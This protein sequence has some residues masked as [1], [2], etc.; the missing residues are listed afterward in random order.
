MRWFEASPC[1]A[2]PEGQPPSLAQLRARD[3]YDHLHRPTSCAR[4]TRRSG[5]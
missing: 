3:P 2:T 5:L 1:K 4:G